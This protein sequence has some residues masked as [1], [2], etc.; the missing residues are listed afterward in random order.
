MLS[1]FAH[2]P[3]IVEREA[4]AGETEEMCVSQ[5]TFSATVA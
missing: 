3:R 5:Q 1:E 4:V 2:S